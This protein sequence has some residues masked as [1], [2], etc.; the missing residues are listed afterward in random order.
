MVIVALCNDADPVFGVASVLDDLLGRL[1]LGQ[2][3]DNL[4]LR[5]RDRIAGLAV[6]LFELVKLQM[7]S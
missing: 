5:A 6:P 1:A 4:P 7:W 3:P 2:Q